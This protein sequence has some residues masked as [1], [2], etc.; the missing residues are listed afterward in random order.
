MA[1]VPGTLSQAPGSAGSIPTLG[2]SAPDVKRKNHCTLNSFSHIGRVGDAAHECYQAAF[3]EDRRHHGQIRQ[4]PGALP[5]II[6]GKAVTRLQGVGWIFLEQTF[7]GHGQGAGKSTILNTVSGLLRPMV[8]EILFDGHLLGSAII[9]RV[10]LGAGPA[11]PFMP[12]LMPLDRCLQTLLCAPR[13]C[14]YARC[15]QNF[16]SRQF[17]DSTLAGGANCTGR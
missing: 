8:G 12:C 6:G 3:P 1:C 7:E 9:P 2:P 5:G 15:C 11:T 16:D 4:M 13:R 14:P 10:F 17:S